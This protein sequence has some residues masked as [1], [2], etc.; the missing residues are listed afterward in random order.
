[1]SAAGGGVYGGTFLNTGNVTPTVDYYPFFA[2]GNGGTNY[3]F[4]ATILPAACTVKAISVLAYNDGQFGNSA[5]TVT[6]VLYHN[7]SAV[8]AATAS[9]TTS[10]TTF[11]TSTG[12]V[13]NL[14]ESIAAGDTIA[15]GIKQ[16]T[17]AP[18]VRGSFSVACQ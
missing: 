5:D 18:E 8:S 3:A 17:S 15:M 13:T 4:G 6:F 1:V 16:S 7:G 14:S 2:S 12:N 10:A 9:V 11:Q